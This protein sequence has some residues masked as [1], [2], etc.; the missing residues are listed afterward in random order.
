MF[1]IKNPLIAI[2]VYILIYILGTLSLTVL[3]VLVLLTLLPILTLAAIAAIYIPM[4]MAAQSMKRWLT[5]S[6]KS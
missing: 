2:P 4:S 3:A 5:R 6:R 1:Q